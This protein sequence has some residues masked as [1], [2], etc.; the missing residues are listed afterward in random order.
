MYHIFF[1]LSSVNGQLVCFHVLAIVNSGAM[2]IG[3]HVSFQIRVF[4]RYMFRNGVAGSCSTSILSL[5]R[6]LHTLLQY[7][8]LPRF[9]PLM[10]TL[11]SSWFPK[12]C[13]KLSHLP[14]STDFLKEIGPDWKDWCWSSNTLATWRKEWL[15]WKDPDAGK[16]WRQEGK[17]MTEVKM[18]GW[19][20]RLNG[21][22]FE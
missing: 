15:I 1:I 14:I 8:V 5:S 21:H 13:P 12:L 9:R 4:S 22:E 7:N 6:N 20:H 11:H 16:D 17:E 18:V 2:N 19:H 10:I 3:V